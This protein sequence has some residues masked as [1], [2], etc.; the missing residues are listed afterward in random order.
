[1]LVTGEAHST[2]PYAKLIGAAVSTSND[3]RDDL[4]ELV[5]GYCNERVSLGLSLNQGPSLSHGLSLFSRSVP[6]PHGEPD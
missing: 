3:V 2:L 1:M 4:R 6:H 5:R